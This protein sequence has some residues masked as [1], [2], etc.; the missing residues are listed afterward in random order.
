MK[1]TTSR[2]G[3]K[4]RSDIK[5]IHI[6]GMMRN[7]EKRQKVD[8]KR[9]GQT[10]SQKPVRGNINKK[11]EAKS[12]RDITDTYKPGEKSAKIDPGLK[13]AAEILLKT[14]EQREV[15]QEWSV[16]CY[17]IAYVADE[18]KVVIG[19]HNAQVR[20]LDT[21][22]GKD[23]WK[24][25]RKGFVSQG[26]DGSLLVS[27]NDNTIYALDPGNGK[28]R[29]KK[30]LEGGANIAGIGDDGTIYADIGKEIHAI[31]PDTRETKWKCK[32]IGYPVVSSDEMIY[33]GSPDNHVYAFDPGTG[34]EKW[35]FKTDGLVR[36]APTVGK[37]GTVFAGDTNGKL[38][39]ID[40]D[41]GEEK[42]N[43]KTG[44]FILVTP[45]IAE[46]GTVYVGSCDHHLYALDP[47]TGEKKWSFDAGAEIRTR[48]KIAPD[49]TILLVSDRNFIYSVNQK[50][51]R[52]IWQ[53]KAD[54]YVHV[55]PIFGDEGK[56]YFGC[57]NHKAYALRDPM[58][59]KRD[60]K[61]ILDEQENSPKERAKIV[62]G[63]G[64]VEIGGVTLPKRKK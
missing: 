32:K 16:D 54:S 24:S 30:K 55:T 47:E 12:F 7:Y 18:S 26:K 17:G 2:K 46:D 31:D 62:M 21:L 5:K 48:P 22:N 13:A 51:G 8:I 39:A 9:T 56:I 35:N 44:N 59:K 6:S 60:V 42:W 38:Y 15:R 33:S 52:K 1:L 20:A 36:C 28:D 41:T 49:D 11:S 53:K 23:K 10:S 25:E 50:N 27:S 14:K 34:E 45:T 4:I 43:F 37:N 61:Q 58:M 57:N 29:W 63:D 64:Y 40:P 19:G 3:Y